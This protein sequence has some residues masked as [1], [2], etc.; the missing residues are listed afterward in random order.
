MKP[1]RAAALA[2]L[3][4][5]GAGPVAAQDAFLTSRDGSISL[6]GTMIGF[7]GEFYRLQTEFGILTVDAEGVRCEGPGCPDLMNPVADIRLSGDA[8]MGRLL[9]PALIETF[10]ARSALLARRVPEDAAN[11]S[12]HLIDPTED[13]L[14]ARFHLSLSDSAAGLAD[15]AADRADLAMANRAATDAE[16]AAGR[17]AGIGDLA[18]PRRARIIALDALVPVVAMRNPVRGISIEQLVAIRAGRLQDWAVLGGPAGVTIDLHETTPDGSLEQ[19]LPPSGRGGE[20]RPAWLVRHES[21]AGLVESVARNPEALGL[22]RFSDLRAVRPLALVGRCGRQITVTPEALKAEDYPLALPL[23]LYVPPRRLPLIAREFLDWLST[24]TA[25]MAV[26]RAGYVDQVPVEIPLAAQGE[27]LAN[28]IAAAGEEVDLAD[29]R[30]L[31]AAMSG[32]GRLTATFRFRNGSVQLDAQSEGNL[33]RLVRDIGVGLYD[34]RQIVL[35]GFSD[36]LGPADANRALSLERA[37]AV[38]EALRSASAGADWS[39]VGLK[40]V[41]FG[42][43]LPLACDDSERGRQANRR[44]EVWVR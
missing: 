12:Y 41:G 5:I 37:E 24:P 22:A 40:A 8:T 36:G 10:A 39:R 16:V 3:L 2:A 14:V 11:L 1:I 15:L 44:V 43:A 32:A 7:D 34:D 17:A 35:A 26:R 30:E 21:G 19:V 23:Y 18:G 28:A 33:D 31:V 4:A 25:E 38:A 42:E 20:G 29:L 9:L 27:R 6:E 13:R